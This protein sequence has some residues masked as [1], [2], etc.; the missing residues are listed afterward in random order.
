MHSEHTGAGDPVRTLQLLWRQPDPEPRRGPRR[1]LSIDA[2]ITSAIELAG[3]TGLAAITIRRVA[4]GLGVAPMTLYTYVPG[5]AEL[6][7]LMLDAV[8]ADL[9]LLDTSGRHWRDRLTAVAEENRALYTRHPWAAEISLA[10]PPLGPG[11]LA[12]Y[13]HELAAFDGLG[14]DDVTVDAALTHL[15]SFVRTCALQEQEAAAMRPE[16]AADDTEWWEKSAPLL[17]K[18]LDPA[19]YPRAVRIGQAAGEAHGAAY[20]PTHA[21]TFGLTL[22]LDGLTTQL[23]T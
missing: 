9:P 15:L 8:F 18:V 6:L 20:N 21:F 1:G 16:G 3:E 12:K 2:V 11:Q 4:T 23:P 17:E 13:E 7:D 10:R 22:L 14:L 19:R 5:K